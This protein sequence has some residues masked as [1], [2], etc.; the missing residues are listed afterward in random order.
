MYG[1]NAVRRGRGGRRVR[2]REEGW[3]E[4]EVQPHVIIFITTL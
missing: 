3:G 1:G 2:E 4:G